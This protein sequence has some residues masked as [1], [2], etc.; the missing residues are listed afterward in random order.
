[1]I[2]IIVAMSENR[3]IGKNNQLPWHLPADL[4]HFKGL[5]TGH[6]VVMGRKTYDSIGKPLPNRPNL[7]ITRQLGYFVE[8]ALVVHDLAEAL[9]KARNLD[10]QV[11]IIGGSEIFTQALPLVDALFITWV[12][13][14]VEGDVYFPELHPD[15]WQEVERERKEADEKHAYGYSFVKMVR[16]G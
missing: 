8:G 16:R 11:F 6:P 1:V 12:H 2:A 4:K 10:E 3:V 14:E 15:E 5:T 7:L 9:K 13:A